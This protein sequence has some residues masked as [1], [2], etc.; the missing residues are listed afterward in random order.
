MPSNRGLAGPT[1]Q[2]RPLPLRGRRSGSG[3]PASGWLA[4]HASSPSRV[5][6]LPAVPLLLFLLALQ[7][8]IPLPLS[9]LSSICLLVPSP[10]LP[11]HKH[12]P[13]P[14]TPPPPFGR[15]SRHRLIFPAAV[16]ARRNLR[17]R[18]STSI[19]ASAAL[20]PRSKASPPFAHFSP[21]Q[22][23]YQPYTRLNRQPPLS[24]PAV[25]I[26][27]VSGAGMI[28]CRRRLPGPP[29]GPPF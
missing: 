28:A 12:L 22:S 27:A 20:V 26:W 14:H 18:S 25:H 3:P 13:H 23:R 2:P 15:R 29:A 8:A 17:R 24:S 4:A 5:P 11:S 19:A 6:S 9:P 10:S 21:S 7:Q 1:P 16:P